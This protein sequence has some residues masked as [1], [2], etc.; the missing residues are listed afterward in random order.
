M[1]F[2]EVEFI[3][4]RIGAI[5]NVPRSALLDES[6]AQRCLDLLDERGVLVFP[7]IG[8][9]EAEQRAFSDRLGARVSAYTISLDPQHASRPRYIE[10]TFFWHMDGLTADTQVPHTTLLTAS[11][12]ANKGGQTD[13]VSTIAA[14][15]SLPETEKTEIAELR[16]VHS[17]YAGLR[18]IVEFPTKEDGE[19][20]GQMGVIKDH[21]IVRTHKSG[22]KSLVIGA[23]ADYI[24]GMP[25]SYGRALLAR[26]LEWATQREFYYR[27]EWQ[28]G[29]LV[30]WNNLGTLHRVIPYD[31]ASGRRMYRTAVAARDG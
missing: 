10:A 21:P 29:D 25:M 17:L 31:G 14:Y 20:W 3:K 5:A 27:H 26:L 11:C 28:E 22:S 13:F 30:L 23:T 4:P 9:S 1:M 19:E 18:P 15:Q 24:A 12:V 8:L 2:I 16:A 6:V 7:R